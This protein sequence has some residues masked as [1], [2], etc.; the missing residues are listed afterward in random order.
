[1]YDVFLRHFMKFKL[2]FGHALKVKN[3]LCLNI[4]L[5]FVLI[6]NKKYYLCRQLSPIVSF[7]FSILH[8]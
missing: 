5:L 2:L 1:M 7:N 6:L 3:A 8:S 4:L